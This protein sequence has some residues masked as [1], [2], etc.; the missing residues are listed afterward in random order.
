MIKVGKAK[1]AKI[2]DELAAL[3][4]YARSMK[5]SSGGWFSENALL[6]ASRTSSSTSQ[7]PLA[8]HSF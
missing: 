3:G 2:A 7:S 8:A 5:P 6:Y 4:F 1:E